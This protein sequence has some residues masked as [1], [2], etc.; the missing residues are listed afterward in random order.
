MRLPLFLILG[1][2]LL[3]ACGQSEPQA[4]GETGPPGPAPAGPPGSSAGG[5]AIRSYRALR[6]N[7]LRRELRRE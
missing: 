7:G 2:L 6:S 5:P 3:A 1:A 4:K